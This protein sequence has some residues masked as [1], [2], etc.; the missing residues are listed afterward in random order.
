MIKDKRIRQMNISS[1]YAKENVWNFDQLIT[2]TILNSLDSLSLKM[3]LT[4]GN[5]FKQIS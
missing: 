3:V 2:I 1:E 5:K 4:I